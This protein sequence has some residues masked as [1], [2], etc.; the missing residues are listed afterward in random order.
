VR[1]HDHHGGM[2]NVIIYINWEYLLGLIGTFIAVAYYANGRLSRME[3]SIEWLKESVSGLQIAVE[4][5]S[6]KLFDI[7]SPIS[8]TAAGREALTKSGLKRYVDSHK[9][10]LLQRV[11]DHTLDA[12]QMQMYAFRLFAELEFDE[13]IQRRLN[14]F[15]FANGV[16]TDMLRRL[17]AI[18]LRDNAAKTLTT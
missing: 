18:Y 5:R 15:A 12:Y 13:P 17:G 4:N 14:R 16:S 7:R 6:T 10:E 1:L 11:G 9:H 8:L 3:I 2:N